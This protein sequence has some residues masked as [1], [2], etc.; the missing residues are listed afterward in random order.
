MKIDTR[1]M[2]PISKVNQNFSQ[3]ARLTEEHGFITIM[4]SNKPKFVLMTIDKFQELDKKGLN[5]KTSDENA[6]D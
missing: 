5:T 2:M 6:E 4:K 3:A 1:K